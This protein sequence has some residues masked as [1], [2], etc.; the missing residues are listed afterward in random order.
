ME[1]GKKIRVANLKVER[2]NGVYEKKSWKE[3]SQ[4]REGLK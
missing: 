2:E 1:T 4:A 3:K